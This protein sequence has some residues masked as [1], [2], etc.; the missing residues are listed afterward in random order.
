MH[1]PYLF[2]PLSTFPQLFHTCCFPTF[3][4]QVTNALLTKHGIDAG[5][6]DLLVHVRV[7]KG[8]VRHLDGSIQ[9]QY[10]EDEV[11]FPLQV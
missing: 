2:A 4:K 6:C 11:T 3:L 8:Y 1:A 10:S 7:C 5:K 9:K